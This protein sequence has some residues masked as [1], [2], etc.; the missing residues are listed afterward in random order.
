MVTFI[1]AMA[2]AMMEVSLTSYSPSD[3]HP[4]TD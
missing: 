3:T 2:E 4:P 1:E